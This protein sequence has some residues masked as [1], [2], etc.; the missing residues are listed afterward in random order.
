[1]DL[2]NIAVPTNGEAAGTSLPPSR[3]NSGLNVNLRELSFSGVTSLDLEKCSPDERI[4]QL[5]AAV[6]TLK[7]DPPKTGILRSSI[8]T[9]EGDTTAV[10][11][12]DSVAL[13]RSKSGC[14]PLHLHNLCTQGD[15][16]AVKALLDSH[17]ASQL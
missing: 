5:H 7:Q 12:H 6:E 15:L 14:A 9:L 10:V 8:G 16:A 17:G 13:A 2:L 3:T 11:A 1:M 4:E